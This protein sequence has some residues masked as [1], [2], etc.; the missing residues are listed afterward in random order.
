LQALRPAFGGTDR[1]ELLRQIAPEAA[2]P[3][4]RPERGMPAELEVIV[5][6]AAE[7]NPQ[8]RYAAAQQ[9]ADD[10][11]RF[12][13]DRPIKARRPSWRQVTMKRA[14]PHRPVV[15]NE[16]FGTRDGEGCGVSPPVN[17]QGLAA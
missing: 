7:K 2:V 16:V 14:R 17:H 15:R 6:K 8:D 11:R 5:L 1:Q 3:P 13:D 10:L 9:L 4:R 12:L